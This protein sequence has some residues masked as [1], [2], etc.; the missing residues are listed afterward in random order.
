MKGDPV[1]VAFRLRGIARGQPPSHTVVKVNVK[2]PEVK[3]SECR[4]RYALA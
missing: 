3:L 1:A 4:A 2:I